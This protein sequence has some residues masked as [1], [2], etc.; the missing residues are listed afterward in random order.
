LSEPSPTPRTAVVIATK[1]RAILLASRTLPSVVEQS[2][3]PDF[4]VVVDDSSPS[5]RSRVRQVVASL[6][7]PETRI[8]YLENERTRGASGAWNT[9]LF[10]LQRIVDDPEDLF[11]AILDDDDAWEPDYLD[12]CLKLAHDESLDMVA[13]DF[14]RIESDDA[15]PLLQEAPSALRVADFLTG[16]PGIQG[17]NLFARLRVFLEAGGF[18]E[19]LMSSTDRD[20]CIR[21]ADLGTV[22]YGR[23]ALPLVRHFAE[24]SRERLSTRGSPA[25]L[26]GLT[27]F[28]K[29]YSGRMTAPQQHAFCERARELFDWCP[30][31]TTD[32]RTPDG[33]TALASTPAV[34]RMAL[35]LGLIADNAHPE[36]LAEKLQDLWRGFDERLVG[37]DVVL[38]E[39]GQRREGVQL[40]DDA[41]AEIRDAG[42]GC[43]RFTLEHQQE[44]ASEGVFQE[45]RSASGVCSR[46][47]QYVALIAKPR[48]GTVAWYVSGSGV[49]QDDASENT[50]LSPRGGIFN[51]L[52]RAG[53][54][55]V[56]GD[57]ITDSDDLAPRSGLR[58]W[59][60]QERFATAEHRVRKRFEPETLRVLGSGSEAVVL[61]DE[62]TVFKC[63][64][65]WKTR[66][67]ESQLAFLHA[68]IGRW[69]GV[70][71]LYPLK[72]VMVDGPWAVITYDYEPS[73]PYCGGHEDELVR[74]LEGCRRVGIVCN[75][76]HPKNLVA[77]ASG[78]KIIDYGSDIRAWTPLGFEHMARR[79]FLACHHAESEQLA[80]LMR[81]A[82]TDHQLP[83]LAGYGRFRARLEQDQVDHSVPP[84]ATA[85]TGSGESSWRSTPVVD[86]PPHEPFNLYAGV[87]SA[88]PEM[89]T[90][91]LRGLARLRACPSIARLVPLILANGNK[92]GELERAVCES[93]KSGLEALFI[94]IERQRL[95]AA[96]GAFGDQYRVRPKGQVTIAQARTMLQR[97]LG[98]LQLRDHGSFAWVLDDDMRI[99][100]RAQTYLPWLPTFRDKGVDA[101][102]GKYEGSSPNPPLNGVRVQLVDLYHSLTWLKAQGPYSPL[103]D[104]RAENQAERSRHPDYYYDLSRK[105]TAHLETPQW[106]EPAFK[107]ETVSQA[108]ARLCKGAL[109]ILSGAPLT[110]PLVSK[111]PRDPLAEA[112][113]SVN[114]GGCTFI[115]NPTTLTMTPNAVVR[116]AG[117]EARRSDM[118]WAIINR[119]YRGKTIK[120]VSFPVVHLGRVTDRP[121]LNFVK[122]V[123]EIVGSAFYGAFTGHLGD[124][125][126]HT[127]DFTAGELEQICE[128]VEHHVE[129]RLIALEQSFHRIRGLT[130]ALTGITRHGELDELIGYLRCWFTP[131]SFS[132]IEDRVR[133]VRHDD[134]RAFLTSLRV[135]AD[136]YASQTADLAFLHRQLDTISA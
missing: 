35:V 3:S 23:L 102:I 14:H 124:R 113:D 29:K 72:E 30:A 97:Y 88:D 134:F 131:A 95:D 38:V 110:R 122:V 10:S 69:E 135:Q 50:L 46:L 20:L 117:R 129:R 119:Y 57:L 132:A 11:V 68:Q 111:V 52:V 34:K 126:L 39:Q 2:R 136:E 17:S 59:I 118:V 128:L 15:S 71:G 115:M 100:E 130:G 45:S 127:L 90:Q 112:S 94:P 76:V 32:A 77:T 60:E 37:L 81:H 44:H 93:R 108:Y 105:H 114:R 89:L 83:E 78:V 58:A 85:L 120:H 91:L 24:S 12:R 92:D 49:L 26:A 53:A 47:R 13:S 123:D 28:W 1:D 98:E 116:I 5:E 56:D 133:S 8:T 103:P 63:I 65:Y 80:T 73:V 48:P 61:T 106:I 121:D 33:G 99:D 7:I 21:I 9:A 27:A 109:G 87:I 4:I 75:N 67:P 82:L 101:L 66:I 36:L 16:N 40:L 51:A 84:S 55:E 96:T 43:F 19:G 54:E 22:G 107:E 42:A 125:P 79:A 41:A 104:R 31:E 74:L 62:H 86:V 70:P 6:A 64:D 18:D 25:K